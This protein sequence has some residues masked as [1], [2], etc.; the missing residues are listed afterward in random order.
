MIMNEGWLGE[1]VQEYNDVQNIMTIA[2]LFLI[3]IFIFACFPQ[4]SNK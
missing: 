4:P 1:V 3:T 2:S